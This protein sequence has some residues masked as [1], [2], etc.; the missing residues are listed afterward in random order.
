VPVSTPVPAIP[1]CVAPDRPP[2]AANVVL[3]LAYP[4]VPLV[5]QTTSLLYEPQ[6]AGWW[7]VLEQRG[8]VVRFADDPA[9]NTAEVVLDIGGA[10]DCCEERGLLGL[11]FHPDFLNN[12]QVFVDYTTVLD[13][14]EH[15][16][17]LARFTSD[18]GGATLDPASEVILL[19]NPKRWLGHNGGN[20]E[21]GDDGYL[22]LGWG[23]GGHMGDPEGYAQDLDT[24][25]GKMLRIDVDRADPPLAYAIPPDNP[26]ALGGGAPEVWAWGFRNPWRWDF[27][28]ATGDLWLGDVG[29]ESWEEVD[30]VHAGGNYGWNVREGPDC[31]D[32]LAPCDSA[33][34]V[35]PVVV[36]PHG[37]ADAVIAG[38]VYHGAALPELQGK[39]LFSDY[40]G[41]DAFVVDSDPVTGLPV[42]L[43]ILNDTPDVS[44]WALG[45][46]GEAYAL[47]IHGSVWRLDRDG[48]PPAAAFPATLAATGCVDPADPTVPA[49]ELVPF[50]P[51]QPFWSD[52]LSK[53]RWLTIP[54]GTSI[55]VNGEGDFDLPIGTV[56]MKE[57]RGPEDRIETRLFVRHTDGG[58]GG[59]TY[60]WRTDGTD[61]DLLAGALAVDLGAATW[62]IPSRSQCLQCHATAAGSSLGLELAQLD[63]DLTFRTGS[64]RINSITWFRS[65]GSTPSATPGRSP[66]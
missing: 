20:V 54:P 45:P 34:L 23:D 6:I 33:G 14:G 64:A 55:G 63:L 21:F 7:Y 26:F 46:D 60:A 66:R 44:D 4:S 38:L 59:Y 50:E 56:L 22:Y 47:S 25:L 39:F 57:F 53:S 9:A 19:E 13:T 17:R 37:T 61:A 24:W 29:Y 58:W 42:P 18:D 16:G 40:S 11:A 27:D 2:T 36:I 48:S 49:P 41:D 51:A 5:D 1:T 3:T 43:V 8:R 12:G 62:D 10:V 30:V 15:A 32:P 28:P 65:G 52:G 35:E 31:L